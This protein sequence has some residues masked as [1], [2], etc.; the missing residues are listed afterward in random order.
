MVQEEVPFSRSSILE[1]DRLH[2]VSV[3][4]FAFVAGPKGDPGTADNDRLL[5]AGDQEQPAPPDR[6]VPRTPCGDVEYTAVLPAQRL[7]SDQKHSVEDRVAESFREL[8]REPGR[9]WADFAEDLIDDLH[10]SG[11]I[12]LVSGG[13]VRDVIATGDPTVV[14][15]LDMTGTA[16]AG[17]FTEIASQRL[18]HVRKTHFHQRVSSQLVSSISDEHGPIIEYKGLQQDGC[19]FQATGADL[20]SDAASRDFT[21]NALY[22]DPVRRQLFDPSRAG[23]PDLMATPRSLTPLRPRL[24]P[25]KAAAIV[26]RAIKF[27]HR[28]QSQGLTVD[29]SA[30]RGLIADL[31]AGCW[32]ELAGAT[33][34]QLRRLSEKLSEDVPAAD[35]RAIATHLGAGV[36]E[37][38]DRLG[39]A[40]D[41]A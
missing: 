29:D 40:T 8:L 39:W 36:P 25:A 16:P 18:A 7:H 10:A 2:G 1:G 13:A 14:N 34:H 9:S 33:R 23:L 21:V 35:A 41:A 12:A 28:W 6:R 17:Q 27:L 26:L 4:G 3:L 11:H 22:Y 15:D 19:R 38:L 20:D 37:L 30:L 32:A 24:D 5:L 31:P